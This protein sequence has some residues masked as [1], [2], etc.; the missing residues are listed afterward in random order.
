MDT[1]N[2]KRVLACLFAA[3]LLLI[4]SGCS[5]IKEN[6]T[7]NGVPIKSLY[8]DSG[9]TTTDA[10]YDNSSGFCEKHPNT[11]VLLGGVIL[12]GLILILEDQ[13]KE[14]TPPNGGGMTQVD[15]P[16]LR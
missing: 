8:A 2:V 15:P 9:Q 12:G 14:P 10:Q 11:C 7:F 16:M 13:G 1:L 6:Y 3:A 5:T 4:T